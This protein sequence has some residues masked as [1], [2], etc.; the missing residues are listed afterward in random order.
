MGNFFFLRCESALRVFY[1]LICQ[2]LL[3]I[4]FYIELLC[5][6]LFCRAAVGC[7]FVDGR[8]DHWCTN[9][10]WV[11]WIPKH[12][13]A[14]LL[15]NNNIDTTS[16]YTEAPKYYITKEPECYTTTNAAPAYY[17]EAPNITLLPATTPR[18]QLIT[19]QKQSNTTQK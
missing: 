10:S 14:V 13:A 9:V 12:D 15:C 4:Y 7:R 5:S 17:T 11:W 3:H 1:F 2:L 18:F 6:K 19:P 8:V 16:Y